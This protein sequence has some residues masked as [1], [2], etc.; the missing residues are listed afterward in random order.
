MAKKRVYVIY[1]ERAISDTD[2]ASIYVAGAE[3]LKEALQDAKDF[4]PCVIYSYEE[5]KFSKDGGTELV[6]ERFEKYVQG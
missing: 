2:Y 1:D 4:K 3:S 6:D 5:G